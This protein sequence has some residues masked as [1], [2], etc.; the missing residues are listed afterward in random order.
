MNSEELLPLQSQGREV[1]TGRDRPS[2][3]GRSPPSYEAQPD[4][5][6][7]SDTSELLRQAAEALEDAK[8][9]LL[10]YSP[11]SRT[12]KKCD[13]VAAALRQRAGRE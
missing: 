5:P 13:L 3:A 8:E 10:D 7:P 4:H 6:C 9:L 12:A 2:E 1:P 11:R